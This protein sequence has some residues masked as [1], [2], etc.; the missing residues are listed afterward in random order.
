[1]RDQLAT[2][3]GR[4]LGVD[5]GGTKTYAV[6]TDRDGRAYGEATVG[7]PKRRGDRAIVEAIAA[8]CDDALRS[9]EIPRDAILSIGIGAPGSVDVASGTW[10]GSTNVLLS[11]PPLELAAAISEALGRPTFVDNDVRAAA[12]GEYRCGEGAHRRASGPHDAFVYISVGTGLAAGV[13]LGGS[14]YRGR[15]E[16]AELGH[17][18]VQPDGYPCSCGQRGCLETVASGRALERWGQGVVEAGWTSALLEA[19]GG[20]ADQVTGQLIHDCA[21]KGDPVATDLMGRLARGIALAVLIALRAY[22]PETVVLGGGVVARGGD[23]LLG[24]TGAALDDIRSAGLDRR[25]R[26]RDPDSERIVAGTL[27]WRAGGI[28]AALI[29]ERRLAG[30]L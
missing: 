1:M 9:A 23:I 25:K 13:I 15:A 8:A 19:S 24:A 4:F 29:A 17:I 6:V 10:N 7:T 12:Y 11:R 14:L 30:P 20:A 3:G 18:V 5:V 16:A 27:G 2:P 26:L 28:G 22:D 21:K